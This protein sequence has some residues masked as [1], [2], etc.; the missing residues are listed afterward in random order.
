MF[1]RRK[2]NGF[3]S[4]A[5]LMAK[6][7][8]SDTISAAPKKFEPIE[9][10]S[11]PCR[12]GVVIVGKGTQI[13][14]TISACQVLEIH[15]VVEA[16]VTTERL[17]VREGGGIRGNVHADNAE[18]SGVVEGSLVSYEHLEINSTG[19]VWADVKYQT[20]AVAKGAILKGSVWNDAAIDKQLDEARESNELSD[21]NFASIDRDGLSKSNGAK[22]DLK[23]NGHNALERRVRKSSLTTSAFE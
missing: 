22:V 19:E 2:T 21:G 18:I 10:V 13:S 7:P 20:L 6:T 23:V 9:P 16:D 5:A 14:G 8:T 4:S 11:V 15:G 17:I 12:D 3:A 1:N